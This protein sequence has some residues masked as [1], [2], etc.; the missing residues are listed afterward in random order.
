[1]TNRDLRLIIWLIASKCLEMVA[2]R[3]SLSKCSQVTMDLK[4]HVLGKSDIAFSCGLGV[5]MKVLGWRRMPFVV[6]RVDWTLI[7]SQSNM[8][9]CW[10]QGNYEH[11]KAVCLLASVESECT[12]DP[13][14]LSPSEGR[15]NWTVIHQL[16]IGWWL[17]RFIPLSC[18]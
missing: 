10:W 14:C 15:T 3:E 12:G 9:V 17:L 2:D 4:L 18:Q 13:K 8:K 5:F 16:P 7:T 11:L 6:H 1:M